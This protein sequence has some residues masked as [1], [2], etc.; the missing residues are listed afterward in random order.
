MSTCRV[1]PGLGLGATGILFFGCMSEVRLGHAVQS[2]LK[3]LK[4]TN[5]D[6]LGRSVDCLRRLT[7]FFVM[8]SQ[9]PYSCT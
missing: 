7:G 4:K 8:E 6:V 5:A 1:R 3:R 2:L 9:P